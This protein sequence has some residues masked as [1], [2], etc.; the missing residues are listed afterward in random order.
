MNPYVIGG[1][2]FWCVILNLVIGLLI[3]TIA[4][5]WNCH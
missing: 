1:A 4:E 3:G 2:C 5:K